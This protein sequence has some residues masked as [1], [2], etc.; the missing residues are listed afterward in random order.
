[1]AILKPLGILYSLERGINRDH[2]VADGTGKR[3]RGMNIQTD[4]ACSV[5]FRT[6]SPD[7]LKWRRH[8]AET[9]STLPGIMH[10]P[11]SR[12]RDKQHGKA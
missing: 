10:E 7:K 4:E 9:P 5:V 11:L 8:S 6:P 3:L 12:A 1:M 2:V